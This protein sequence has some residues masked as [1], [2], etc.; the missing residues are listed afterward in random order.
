ML[1]PRLLLWGARSEGWTFY[2]CFQITNLIIVF[3]E[4]EPSV[5]IPALLRMWDQEGVWEL[6]SMPGHLNTFQQ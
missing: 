5:K 2:S 1:V 3:T 6:Q 4:D